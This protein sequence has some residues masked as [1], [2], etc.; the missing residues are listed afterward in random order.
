MSDPMDRNHVEPTTP[1]ARRTSPLV[2]LLL[3]VAL[4][5]LGWY[6]Y[7]R[8]TNDTSAVTTPTT[9]AIEPTAE[10]AA[11]EAEREA[12]AAAERRR[13]ADAAKATTPKPAPAPRLV[14]ASPV[15]G[16]SPEPDYPASSQR[17]GETGTVTLK[18]DVGAD[19]VPTNVDFV[20]RSGSQDLDRA[21]M[22][23][24]KKWRFNPAKRDGKAIASSVTV[25]VNFVLPDKG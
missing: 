20:D 24:V 17:R 8:S 9:D 16:M 21:A 5:A 12:A 22:N 4:L 25:P 18:V 10:S 3:L 19:G 13:E 2:W 11:A 15:A 6:F 23:A 1:P 14:D 7:S